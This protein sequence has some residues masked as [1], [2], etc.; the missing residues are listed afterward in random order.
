[1]SLRERTAD[2][3]AKFEA[4]NPDIKIKAESIPWGGGNDYYTRLFAALVAGDGSVQV[5]DVR[6]RG[7]L[8]GLADD[9]VVEV[10]VLDAQLTQALDILEQIGIDVAFFVAHGV[11]ACGM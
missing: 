6:N 3:V 9:D 10:P 2:L 4:A 11:A 8:P 1:M 7:A 5:L